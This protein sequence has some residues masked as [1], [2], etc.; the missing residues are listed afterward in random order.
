MVSAASFSLPKS[1]IAPLLRHTAIFTK[2]HNGTN[3]SCSQTI[4]FKTKVLNT[5]SVYSVPNFWLFSITQNDSNS[6][7]CQWFHSKYVWTAPSIISFWF[8]A[9]M[10]LNSMLWWSSLLLS[11]TVPLW[12]NHLLKHSVLGVYFCTPKTVLSLWPVT[13]CHTEALNHN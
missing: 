7:G 1:F 3:R 6:H 9:G 5:D 12:L 13:Y 8:W 11:P 4:T 2:V 10:N